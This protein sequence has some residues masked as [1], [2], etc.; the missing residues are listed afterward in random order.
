MITFIMNVLLKFFA[1]AGY[2]IIYIYANELFP[3]R[4]RNTGMGICSMIARKKNVLFFSVAGSTRNS[5]IIRD[6]SDCW[7]NQ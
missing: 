7:N 6:W 2:N 3:T 4:I 1:S 5:L